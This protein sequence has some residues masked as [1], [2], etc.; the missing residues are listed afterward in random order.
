MEATKLTAGG[1][2]ILGMVFVA[3][4]FVAAIWD[5]LSS[6]AT[7][8]ALAEP[9][10]VLVVGVGPVWLPSLVPWNLAIGVPLIAIGGYVI[11]GYRSG[12]LP[13]EP[14]RDKY[15]AGRYK[16]PPL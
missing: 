2:P 14:K 11:K 16:L 6:G 7:I 8:W 13:R 4:F 1:A 3:L 5:A 12:S 9:F 15:E 10:G